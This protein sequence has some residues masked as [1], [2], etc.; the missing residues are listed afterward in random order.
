MKNASTGKPEIN[1]QTDWAHVSLVADADIN[2]DIDS[3]TT[4][5][6]DWDDSHA[7]PGYA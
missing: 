2:H 5:E 1:N 3:S 7:Y 4:T 6:A